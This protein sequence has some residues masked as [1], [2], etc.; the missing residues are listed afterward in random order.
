MILFIIFN[1]IVKCSHLSAVLFADD[2][3]FLAHSKTIKLL[4]KEMNQE[5]KFIYDSVIRNKLTLNYKKTKY[6]IFQNK[7][8]PKIKK[9]MQKFK[10]NINKYCIKRVSE[11]KYLGIIFDDK[12]SWKKHIEHL[13]AKLSK[14]AGVI[15]KL[16]QVSPDNVLKMV[17][18]SIVASHLRYGITTWGT[19]SCTALER[20]NSIHN[21][22]LKYLKRNEE[23][24][25]Q[26]QSRLQIFNIHN[27]YKFEINKLVY[28]IQKGPAPD[29]FTDFFPSISHRYG[30]RS[31]NRG[32]LDLP[33]PNTERDKT[34]LRYQG[35][36]HWNSLPL[37][38]K[39]HNTRDQ[40]LASLKTFLI[41]QE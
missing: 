29:A 32:D 1:D 12:L 23:S 31:R 20:L 27:L 25:H 11:F 15:Y 10:I 24:L 5:V 28:L 17:Y 13:C 19:A 39:S 41:D 9:K 33:R 14:A 34:A 37:D 3:V 26:T 30:T 21:K 8:D 6:M 16:K 2:A 35:A 4:E 7:R 36:I 38:L 18:H 22:V 40:F